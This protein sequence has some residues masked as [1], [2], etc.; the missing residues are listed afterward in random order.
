MKTKR[1]IS[2]FVLGAVLAASF[3]VVPAGS[4]SAASKCTQNV[5]ASG[6]YATCIGYIQIMLNEWA[7]SYG[8]RT[9]AV[10]NS[11]GPATKARVKAFQWDMW[12]PPLAQDGVVGPAT[13]RALCGYGRNGPAA[14]KQAA[15]KAGC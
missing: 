5:Y 3:V 10:D 14:V 2:T 7:R 15:T 12:N 8:I 13:W 1:R 11:F 4:A 9:I 6:G